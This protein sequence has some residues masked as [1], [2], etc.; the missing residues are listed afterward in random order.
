MKRTNLLVLFILSSCSLFSQDE[1]I[2]KNAKLISAKVLQITSDDIT[3]K[4]FDHLDGPDFV[5]EMNEVAS[6]TFENGKIY[7]PET[8]KSVS[9]ST[10]SLKSPVVVDNGLEYV[11]GVGFMYE[12]THIDNDKVYDF[13]QT[14]DLK[15]AKFYDKYNTMSKHGKGLIISGS[16]IAGVGLATIFIPSDICIITGIVC[17]VVGHPL[18]AAGIPLYIIGNNKKRYD[19][20][21][22]FNSKTLQPAVNLSINASNTGIGLALNF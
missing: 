15:T 11:D 22:M 5:I 14:K 16:I 2:T 21:K 18:L 7:V 4:A 10:Q 6:I 3:Y 8:Q 13:L 12:N 9:Q 20:V 19:T 1:I 17:T